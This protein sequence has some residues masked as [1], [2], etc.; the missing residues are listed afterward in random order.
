[1]VGG[2]TRPDRETASKSPKR[3]L[4]VQPVALAVEHHLLPLKLSVPAAALDP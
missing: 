4:G 1:M 3:R 2:D